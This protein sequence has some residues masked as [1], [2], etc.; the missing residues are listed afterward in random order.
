MSTTQP[1][2]FG[3]YIRSSRQQHSY[4]A[5]H[6]ATLAG[7]APSTITRIEHNTLATPQPDLLLTLITHLDLDTG[8]AVGL[9][10][11]YQR[12]TQASLPGLSDYLRIKY[13]MTAQDIKKTDTYIQQ[14]GY[15]TTHG[16]KGET[17]NASS[18]RR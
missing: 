11:G 17:P 9:L 10:G 1:R 15:D 6:L 2:D 18:P 12:L 13:K 14:L 16:R 3:D 7:V 4:S 5:R 8:T